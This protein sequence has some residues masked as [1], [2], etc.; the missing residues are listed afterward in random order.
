MSNHSRSNGIIRWSILDIEGWRMHIAATE[1][2]LCY[3]GSPDRPLDELHAW[4]RRQ[5]SL[6]GCTLMRDDRALAPYGEALAACLAGER[7]LPEA[8]LDLH[9]T[10][11]RQSVWQQL[12]AIPYG[13]A[14]SY[15]DIANRLGKPSAAR[16]VGS[17]IGANPVLIAVPC[18][19][20]VGK[21]GALTGYRGGVDMKER[22]LKLERMR[23]IGTQQQQPTR[24]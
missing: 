23:A 20:V 9:G 8:F 16:A 19:R 11:F 22:L 4:L 17:A 21:N 1:A 14:I 5:P 3:V 15:T 10:P 7:P 6:G 24:R 13:Q 18:H 12:L 2:G